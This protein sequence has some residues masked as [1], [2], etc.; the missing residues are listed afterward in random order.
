MWSEPEVVRHISGRASTPEESWSRLLRYA[1]HWEVLGY[2]YWA[3]EEKSTGLFVG[4]LGLADYQ[5]QMEPTFE[6][7][8]EIGWVL[9]TSAHGKGYATEAVKRVVLWA[10]A[11][12]RCRTACMITPENTASIRVADKCGYREWK[13]ADYKGQPAIL[14]RREAS[15]LA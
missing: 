11:E 6:G 3:L 15:S 4:E 1:G 12:L 10:D 13:R 9:A 14:F 2:G 5:R 7:D 8:P